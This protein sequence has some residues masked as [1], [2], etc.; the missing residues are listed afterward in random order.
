MTDI[1]EVIAKYYS[2][3]DP[4]GIMNWDVFDESNVVTGATGSGK[5]IL[6]RDEI[7]SKLQGVPLWILDPK[8]KF[9]DCGIIVNDIEKLNKDFQYVFQPS[10]LSE[11]MFR[12][13]CGKLNKLS[14]IHAI[15]DEAP[16]WLSK[17]NKIKEHYDLVQSKR[18]D[19][20]TVTTIATDTKAIPNYILRNV[21]HVYSLRY[22]LRSDVDWLFDYIGEKAEF[23]LTPDKREPIETGFTNDDG[24]PITFKDLPT[25]APYSYVYRDLRKLDASIMRGFAVENF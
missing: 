20:V 21:T 10:D 23:L 4:N 15:I 11:S 14:N 2:P 19:G 22:N 25:L 5:S 9:S 17:Q 8:K 12:K 6:T 18:N 3:D 13:F 1:N 16:L 7:V 24:T